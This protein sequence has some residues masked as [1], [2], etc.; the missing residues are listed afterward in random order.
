[1]KNIFEFQNVTNEKDI[2]GLFLKLIAAFFMGSWV[3]DII[4][5]PHR[6]GPSMFMFWVYTF[7][8]LTLLI[9][10][11]L[12]HRGRIDDNRALILQTLVISFQQYTDM[13]VRII[14]HGPISDIIL[15]A[16]VNVMMIPVIAAGLTTMKK[17]P[18]ILAGICMLI[19]CA[20][21][22]LSGSI[23]FNIFVSL[24][25][26]LFGIATLQR[27]IIN[28]WRRTEQTKQ[29][30]AEQNVVI[31]RFFNLTDKKFEQITEGKLTRSKAA[32]LLERAEKTASTALI[33]RVKDVIVKEETVKQAIRKARA[34]LTDKDLQLCCH[35]AEGLTA[36]EIAQIYGQGIS[37][38]TVHRHRLRTKLGLKEGD[39]LRDYIKMLVNREII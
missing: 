8:N 20:G 34:G 17:L 26:Q 16:S 9:L 35:I 19:Y 18:F 7:T 38:I 5:F 14:I 10:Y 31:S 6:S 11:L 13:A 29:R 12:Y 21:T 39:S 37:T 24:T 2:R 23:A 4:V 27:L 25:L 15:L 33:D 22:Y 32:E 36:G 30:I 3:I 28:A 1:M